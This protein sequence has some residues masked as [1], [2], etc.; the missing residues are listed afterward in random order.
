MDL[1][2]RNE[3]ISKFFDEAY[4]IVVKK[5]VDYEPSGIAFHNLKAE[6]AE[7]GVTP[8][9]FLL[10]HAS[11]HWAA[12]R[13]YIQNGELESESIHSRLMDLANYAALFYCLILEKEN[14][15]NN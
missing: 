1:I 15:D 4:E 2:E 5:G 6:A 14:A 9:V 7:L 11:K 12:L 10:T 8:E 3:K 13:S